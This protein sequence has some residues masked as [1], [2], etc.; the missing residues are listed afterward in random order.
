MNYNFNENVTL[1]QVF[2][3]H[4]TSKSQLAGLSVSKT[5]VE[6]GLKKTFVLLIKPEESHFIH[7]RRDEH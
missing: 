7:Q 1:P 4:F 2:F 5:L 6:N 3:K